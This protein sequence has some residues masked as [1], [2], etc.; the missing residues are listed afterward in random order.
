MGFTPYWDYKP[1]VFQACSPSVYTSDKIL[2][3][4]TRDKTHVKCD[5]L[6][7]S[8]VN[9]V[10]EPIPFSFVF[11]EPAGYKVFYQPET[12]LYKKQTNLFGKLKL[13]SRK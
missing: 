13:F 2:H 3:L 9:G 6:N 11:K 1:T 10:R 7:G 12:V 4:S 8:I 5:C